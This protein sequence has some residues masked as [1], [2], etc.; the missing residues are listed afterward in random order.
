[1]EDNTLP[2]EQNPWRIEIDGKSLPFWFEEGKIIVK[3]YVDSTN[4]VVPTPR[5]EYYM[6]RID[7]TAEIIVK[8]AQDGPPVEQDQLIDLV[9]DQ[10]VVLD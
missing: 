8:V 1:M 5:P 10:A 2:T 3:G 4:K 6:I 9:Q 7:C